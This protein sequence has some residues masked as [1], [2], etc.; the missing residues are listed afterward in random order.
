MRRVLAIVACG[1]VL[2]L[3]GE[4]LAQAGGNASPGGSVP[5]P[6]SPDQAKGAKAAAEPGKPADVMVAGNFGQWALIC[7]KDKDKDGKEPCSLV[8]ALIERVAKARVSID[9]GLRA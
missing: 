5:K 7:G 4:A 9:C 2:V 8:E 3:G 1:L 6:V